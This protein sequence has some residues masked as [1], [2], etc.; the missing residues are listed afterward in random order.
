MLSAAIVF[1]A[2]CVPFSGCKAVRVA[3]PEPDLR[4]ADG[5][6][7]EGDIAFARKDFYTALIKY[8]ESVR[9]NPNNE[10]V[11]N[12]LGIAYS[13]LTYLQQAAESFEH[14]IRI[15]PKYPFSYNNLGSIY[16]ARKSLKEAE[17]YFK[18]AISL[19]DDEA[20]FH[21]NLGSLYLEKKKRDKAMTEWRKGLAIDPNVLLKNSAVSLIG[22]TAPTKERHYFMARLL[23]AAGKTEPAIENLKL[24][25][26]EGF[27]DLESV[28]KERDFDPVR[29]DK[30]F[31]DFMEQTDLLIRLKAKIGLPGK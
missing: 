4:R 6:S 14:S 19:K 1:I 16:F 29:K 21:M 17:R 12:K 2:V 7:Q 28:R 3:V 31:I 15:N 13:Q 27:T 9:F 11:Y 22:G 18:K 24:A 8:L 10:F 25:I 26:S 30:R 20:S 23:A 5:A